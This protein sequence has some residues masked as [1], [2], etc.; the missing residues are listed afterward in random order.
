MP[1]SITRLPRPG[2]SVISAGVGTATMGPVQTIY[3]ALE[4]TTVC[5]YFNSFA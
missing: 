3:P 5:D 1:K 4:F 2:K